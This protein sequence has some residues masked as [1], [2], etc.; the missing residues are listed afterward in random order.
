MISGK[1]RPFKAANAGNTDAIVNLGLLLSDRGQAEQ[2]EQWYRKAPD[3]G[4][5]RAKAN[6][7]NLLAEEGQQNQ[8][9]SNGIEHG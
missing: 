2:A 4:D 7:R 5:A 6:L 3:A 1:S 8:I 9:S